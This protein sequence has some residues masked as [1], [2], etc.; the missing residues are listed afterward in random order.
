M[1]EYVIFSSNLFIKAKFFTQ[2][3]FTHIPKIFFQHSS[4]Y[5][6]LNQ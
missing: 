1:I 2:D 3:I 4:E 6:T 5:H